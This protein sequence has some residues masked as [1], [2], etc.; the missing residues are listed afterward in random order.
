[1]LSVIETIFFL[2]LQ[3]VATYSSF[4][5]YY[6]VFYFTRMTKYYAISDDATYIHTYIHTDIHTYIQTATSDDCVLATAFHIYVYI[7]IDT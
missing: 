2:V 1:L 6:M 7:Y 4:Y 3:T 5:Y